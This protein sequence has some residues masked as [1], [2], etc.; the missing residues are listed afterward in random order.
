MRTLRELN[1]V[2]RG[3]LALPWTT[4]ARQVIL[5]AMR[6]CKEVTS[7]LCAHVQDDAD[8]S[9][10]DDDQLKACLAR[11]HAL[12]HVFWEQTFDGSWLDNVTD[13][14]TFGRGLI[15]IASRAYALTN[16]Y[17]RWA[18]T[19]E[20]HYEDEFGRQGIEMRDE[21]ASH[22]FIFHLLQD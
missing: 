1:V 6:E 12:V 14:R 4:T 15:G 5:Q 8:S 2:A 22:V 19:L 17:D 3:K 10:N 21:T 13:N 16:V 11:W 7:A 20:Q 9:L 18:A